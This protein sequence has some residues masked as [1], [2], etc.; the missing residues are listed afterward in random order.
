MTNI[1][2]KELQELKTWDEIQTITY[3]GRDKGYGYIMTAGHGYIAVPTGDI[4]YA[5]AKKL[6][7]FK[8]VHA[9]YLEEDCD[10]PTFLK[11]IP[12]PKEPETVTVKELC[13]Q[14][15]I[16]FTQVG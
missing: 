12:E 11:S 1:Y 16:S 3:E 14:M 7:S 13:S 9:V 8:G 6:A 4:H 15:G 10:A 2:L 5:K